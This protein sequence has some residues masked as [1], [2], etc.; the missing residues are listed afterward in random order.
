MKESV[1]ADGSTKEYSGAEALKIK[2]Q[3][4]MKENGKHIKTYGELACFQVFDWMLSS[5]QKKELESTTK[6]LLNLSGASTC[7][8]SSSSMPVA[9]GKKGKK[10]HGDDMTA[11]MKLFS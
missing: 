9:T 7:K 6:R 3:A 10:D 5:T 1:T 4:V 2:W 8:A 11:T